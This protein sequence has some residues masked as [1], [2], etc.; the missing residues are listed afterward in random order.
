MKK[1][2]ILIIIGVAL[3]II[4]FIVYY[5]RS[6]KVKEIDEQR[7]SISTFL[8]KDDNINKLAYV[9][10]FVTPVI[11]AEYQNDS[12]A[13]YVVYDNKY[14]SVLYMNK[15]E[16]N[17]ITKDMVNNGYKIYGVTKSKPD[18]IEEYGLKFL[19]TLFSTHDEDD[20]HNHEINENSYEEYLGNIF[21]DT[22][23][24]KYRN[25]IAYNYAIYI[26]G[27][28]GGFCLLIPI[29]SLINSKNA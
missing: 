15:K 26:L 19:E 28:I 14:Y 24:S 10:T 27:I 16:A 9:K 6:L 21:L 13:F 22:T 23:I 8:E 17:K 20:G 5:G 12:N 3:I 1:N 11:I 2:N 4:M 29:Y 7:D 18:G 25:T